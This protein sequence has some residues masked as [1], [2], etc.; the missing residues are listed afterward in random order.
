MGL[1]EYN[2]RVFISR[3]QSSALWM[4]G[5]YYDWESP[6]WDGKWS[7]ECF[8]WPEYSSVGVWDKTI[9]YYLSQR[10]KVRGRNSQ[11]CISFSIQSIFTGFQS[12][13]HVLKLPI[14]DSYCQLY[15]LLKSGKV[16]IDFFLMLNIKRMCDQALAFPECV[17]IPHWVG[18]WR[19]LSAFGRKQRLSSLEW[20]YVV[21]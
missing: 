10:E 18:D 19:R 12:F 9:W 15:K 11:L 1:T 3:K 13:L 14:L 4:R 2:Q 16:T 17:R 5:K 21:G 7:M 8:G 20:L 6:S